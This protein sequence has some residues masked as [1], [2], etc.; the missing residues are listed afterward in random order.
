MKA[1][2]TSTDQVVPIKA[3]GFEGQTMARVWEGVTEAGVAFTAYIPLVQ[4][5][6]TADNSQFER[7]LNEHKRPM[8]DTMKAIAARMF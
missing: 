5:H 3:V 4:V 8:L 7:E 2:I 6:K 1:Q